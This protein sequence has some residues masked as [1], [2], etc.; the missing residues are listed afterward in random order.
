MLKKI[1]QVFLRT[2]K[3]KVKNINLL[4]PTYT[5]P[6]CK[7]KNKHF[8]PIGF[9]YKV[10]KSKQII[11]AGTRL[12]GCPVCKSSDRER[13]VFLYLNKEMQLFKK[14][15]SIK[16]LHIA[17][18][19]NLTTKLLSS[20][21]NNY[22]CGDLFE[23]GYSY[24]EHVKCMDVLNLPFPNNFFDVIICNHV[25]EHIKDDKRAICELYRVMKKGGTGILQVPISANSKQTLEDN[26]VLESSKRQEVFGQADHVR[27][28]GQDY[29]QTL[30]KLGFRVK[31][32]NISDKYKKFKLN[33]KEDLFIAIK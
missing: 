28:Y 23:P 2:L 9:P 4:R 11:G 8:E 10:I 26:S 5:C 31:R 6:F 19:N 12:M 21:K 27:L 18:E 25:L 14:N 30:E 16:I 15:S 1:R 7:K 29:P 33:K 24:P 20:F 22:Y 3:K 13:L 32:I 17:P